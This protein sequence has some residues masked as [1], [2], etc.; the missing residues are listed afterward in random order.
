MLELV[1]PRHLLIG[2]VMC[3]LLYQIHKQNETY[4]FMIVT[5]I[6]LCI[7][8]FYMDQKNNPQSTITP[9]DDL[10]AVIEPI[11][12]PSNLYKTY[13]NAVV[14]KYSQRIP[15]YFKLIKALDFV[16]KYDKQKMNQ[17]KTYGERFFKTHYNIM[18]EQYE[19]KLYISDLYDMK[20]KIIEVLQELVFV[21][22]KSSRIL[23]IK[24]IDM[25]VYQTINKLNAIL[26]RYI[27]IV[28]HAY[29]DL[30]RYYEP[31]FEYA[32]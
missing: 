11:E 7:I 9:T 31:P 24:N 14:L 21:L 5:V 18:I 27:K 15:D 4:A 30:G 12:M 13:K 23:S 22:P 25:F 10:S 2:C 29:P 20:Q 32:L 6:G 3:I 17:V 8:Y 16:Y 26:A 1:K 19:P 28:H